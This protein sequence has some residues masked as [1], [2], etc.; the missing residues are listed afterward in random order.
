MSDSIN[1]TRP[2]VL[3]NATETQI[4]ELEQQFEQDDRKSWQT[5]TESYGWSK[6]DS[7]AVWN[8]FG[9]QPSGQR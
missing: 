7:E 2:S 4:Q 5:L 9:V 8:W 3:D 6:E 1:Q